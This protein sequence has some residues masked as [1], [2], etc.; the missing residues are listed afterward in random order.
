MNSLSINY[1]KELSFHQD[2]AASLRV[3][4]EYRGRQDLYIRQTPEVLESL[5]RVSM[6]ESVESSN[7]LE[8]ITASPRRL[9]ALL[10]KSVRP[11]DRSEQ[12]IAGYQDALNLIHE[13][14][15]DMPF[16]VGI[17]RQLHSTI[18]RYLPQ[19]GG[20][21]K[22]V[23]NTI[24]ERGSR[25]ETTRVRFEAVPAVATPGAMDA[26]VSLYSEAIEEHPME[27]LVVVPLA[28]L[29]FLCI[30]P[31]TDGNGRVARLLTLLLL[32]HHGI[33]VGR[34]ISLERIFEESREAYYDTLERSS[35]GWHE[36][37]HDAMPWIGYFWGVL[38][39]AYREFERRVGTIRNGRGGKSERVRD[40]VCRR[41]APFAI[42]DIVV[43]CPG[44]SLETIRSV[45]RKMRDEGLLTLEGRGRGSRWSPSRD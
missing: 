15:E 12:E 36:A 39:R 6:V 34:Y 26:L 5:R 31:F 38:I 16:S 30:H 21:W 22:A 45:L 20:K 8:G 2:I 32:Y 42:S 33:E 18:Y 37:A 27:P 13:S 41:N 28:V 44:V 1:L 35:L 40:A 24:V 4:G 23:D 10:L 29:D 19:D 11:R 9:K 14:G 3:I 43:D 7:R 17:V 25:G